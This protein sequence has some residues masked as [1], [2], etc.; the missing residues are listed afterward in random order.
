MVLGLH[1]SLL[2]GTWDILW[3]RPPYPFSPLVV[4]SRALEHKSWAAAMALLAQGLSCKLSAVGVPGGEAKERGEAM[5][6]LKPQS[7]IT[8]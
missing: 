7:A 1:R 5:P 8:E 4:S 2:E 3:C 6:I